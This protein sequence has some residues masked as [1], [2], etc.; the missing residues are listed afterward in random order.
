MYGPILKGKKVVLQPP[1][2]SEAKQYLV[3]LDDDEVTRYISSFTGLDLEKEKEFLKKIGKEKGKIY[4]SVYTK[5]GRH[6]GSTSLHDY[7]PNHKRTSW[8]IIIG[9]KS[10]WNKGYG[11]DILRTVMAYSFNK[12]KLNRFEL[13]VFHKNIAGIKC[14]TKCGF[15][16]EGVRRNFFMK[17]DEIYD[18]IMMSVLKNEYK[19][20][21]GVYSTNK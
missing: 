12:L 9:D 19:S 11:A 20:C 13:E 10:Q 4:W 18:S 3:W 17:N 15:K 16:K 14:Y 1:K 6:I 7:T 8:G 5:E 2:M 21:K